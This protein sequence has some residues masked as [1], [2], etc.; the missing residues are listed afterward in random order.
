M[1]LLLFFALLFVCNRVTAQSSF[2]YDAGPLDSFVIKFNSDTTHIGADTA[3]TPLWQIASNRKSFFGGDTTVIKMMTDSLNP[4]PTKANNYFVLRIPNISHT[5]ITFWHRYQTDSGNDGGL[6]EYS[7]DHGV[8][9][10]NVKDSCNID[11]LYPNLGI[12][13]SG[14]Y[15]LG[16]TLRSGGA[17]FSG[18]CDTTR[19]SAFQF[20]GSE[21]VKTTAGYHCSFYGVDTLYI[22]FRF[23]SDTAVDTLAGWAIDS[24]KVNYFRQSSVRNVLQDFMLKTYPNPSLSGIFQFP[25]LPDEKKLH[26]DILSPVGKIILSQPYTHAIDLSRFSPGMYIYRVSGGDFIYTGR[27]GYE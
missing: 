22:R 6:V 20:A 17:A 8:N 24:V 23:V 2:L 3:S 19:M 27:L 18:T 15:S 13:T 5:L 26:I 25:E 7:R 11:G 10:F 14:F 21:A 1:R 16:D 12:V 4:Y 9:W